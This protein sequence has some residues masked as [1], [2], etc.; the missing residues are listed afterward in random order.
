MSPLASLLHLW[1][2][3][4]SRTTWIWT[5]SGTGCAARNAAG[6]G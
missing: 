2:S 1:R 5:R 4:A 3:F 6:A